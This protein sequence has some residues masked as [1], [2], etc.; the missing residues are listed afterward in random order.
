MA[1][2]SCAGASGDYSAIVLLRW[3]GDGAAASEVV[4]GELTGLFVIYGNFVAVTISSHQSYNCNA[5]LKS[6]EVF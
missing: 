4:S 2:A 3:H 1:N 5:G 6:C